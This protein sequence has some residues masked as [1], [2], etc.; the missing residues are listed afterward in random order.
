MPESRLSSTCTWLVP[1]RRTVQKDVESFEGGNRGHGVARSTLSGPV[2]TSSSEPHVA[3]EAYSQAT[4]FGRPVAAVARRPLLQCF[5]RPGEIMERRWAP[6]GWQVWQPGRSTTRQLGAYEIMA[7]AIWVHAYN[8]EL[9]KIATKVSRNRKSVMERSR[10]ILLARNRAA[11][12]ITRRV[13]EQLCCAM[14]EPY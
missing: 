11:S 9:P 14:V 3:R 13:A 10:R 1:N 8:W 12:N 7:A 2:S 5:T 4:A 6:A